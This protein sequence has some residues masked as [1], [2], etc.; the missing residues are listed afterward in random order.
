METKLQT[1]LK[2]VIHS[3]KNDTIHYD[4]RD[5]NSCNCGLVARALLHDTEINIKESI[6]EWQADLDK[7]YNKV[8]GSWK[9]GIKYLC[10]LTGLSNYQIFN[11]LFTRGMSREDII[12]LEYMDNPA[13]LKK[14]GLAT[15]ITKKIKTIDNGMTITK[16]RFVPDQNK[17]KA[18]FGIGKVEY[19]EAPVLEN[20]EYDEITYDKEFEYGSK[21]NLI[22]YL[23]AWL[24]IITE[25]NTEN[26]TELDRV[27]LEAEL[28]KSLSNEDYERASEIRDQIFELEIIK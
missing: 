9:N 25:K 13:I 8:E 27:D 2:L 6:K 21:E 16:S 3:L 10:P 19:Y 5:P 23:T 1:A 28:L 20:V 14:S 17:F 12:H 18:F 15:N 24:D 22:L 26:I 7:Q 4:W 11:E